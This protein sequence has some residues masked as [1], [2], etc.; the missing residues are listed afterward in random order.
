MK[1]NFFTIV[2]TVVFTVLFS[3]IYADIYHSTIVGGNW[4]DPATWQEGNVPG[5]TDDVV[6]TSGAEVT[7]YESTIHEC[8]NI[9]VENGAILINRQYGNRTLVVHG[10]ITNN[11]TIQDSNYDLTIYLEGDFTHDGIASCNLL[12][13][14]GDNEH[15]VVFGA[16]AIFSGENFQAAD[17][18]GTIHLGSD[19]V[20]SGTDVNFNFVELDGN[21]FSIKMEEE[22]FF[23]DILVRDFTIS[24]KTIIYAGTSFAGNVIVQ[25]TLFKPQFTNLDLYIDGNLTNNGVITK[26]NF[27]LDIYITGDIVNNGEWLTSI[28]HFTGTTTQTISAAAGKEFTASGLEDDDINSAIEALSDLRLNNTTIDLAGGSLEFVYSNTL[29]MNNGTLKNADLHMNGGILF[30]D[31]GADLGANLNISDVSL[32]GIIQVHGNSIVF[33]GEI[34]NNAYL[35]NYNNSYQTLTIDGNI[36]NN[37]TITDPNYS[38]DINVTGNIENNGLWSNLNTLFTGASTHTLS[39]D[40]DAKFEGE[41]FQAEAGTGTITALTDLK[42]TNTTI[43]LNGGTLIM[44]VSKGGS[45]SIF[46]GTLKN[47][48]LTGNHGI[49]LMED[50]SDLGANLN[51]SDVSLDGIIQVHGNSIVFTGEIINNAYLRNYNNSYQTITIDG[52]ITNNDTITDPNYS[53]DINVTGNIENNGLWSNL[54]TLFTGA[55]THTLSQDTDAKFEGEEFQAEAGTGAITALTDLKFTNTTID[56]NGGTLIMPVS[57][58][59]V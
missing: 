57:K 38:L 12:R 44:P 56:L 32:D 58:V 14:T 18:T 26:P 27:D 9:T 6:I 4:H 43:D 50:G 16:S 28:I 47:G 13:F 42:F 39:Q 7:I 49:L 48:T 52:N 15:N 46:N 45:L 30:M 10:D 29:R 51:I 11:G 8:N 1:T 41:E 25:D 37:D 5:S 33:T 54:N 21:G 36:T 2:L 31:N 20:F 3:A 22:A 59:E 19:I 40:T 55:S 35:R 34:I 53:L 23:D 24:G 17:T